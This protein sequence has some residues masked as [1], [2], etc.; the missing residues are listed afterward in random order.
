MMEPEGKSVASPPIPL[1]APR[2][3]LV[4]V[5][6]PGRPPGATTHATPGASDTEADATEGRVYNVAGGDWDELV[7]S[8]EDRGTNEQIVVNMGPQH[9][10][11]HGVLRLILTL[12][13]ET[14]TDARASIG[15]L[16]TGIEKN[17]E[18][19]T[20][21][22]GSTFITRARSGIRSSMPSSRS[23]DRQ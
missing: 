20:W 17:M 21:T 2:P 22:Q 10:S 1:T 7:T 19:R 14:V 13:G 18:Y 4:P 8:D 9:P 16:H 3:M 15:Y 23:T 5:A 12:E 6:T 11:T